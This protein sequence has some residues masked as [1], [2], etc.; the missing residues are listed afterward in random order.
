MAGPRLLAARDPANL[1]VTVAITL[2]VQAETPDAHSMAIE[3]DDCSLAGE[4]VDR[5]AAPL[6]SDRREGSKG[7]RACL[8]LISFGF[9][10]GPPPANHVFDVSFLKNPARENGWSLWSDPG[11]KMREWVVQQP[12]ASAFVQAALP[13][14]RVL[15][16]VDEDARVA[17]GCSAGRH[18]SA[19]LV[20]E[21]ARVLR[22]EN[23]EVSVFHRE[24]AQLSHSPQ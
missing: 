23:V 24:R 12:E 3:I 2:K 14:L 18:R 7:T 17:F 13:L 11:P 15:A 20:E 4:R 6:P 16:R 9:K 10:Y 8:T 21:I 5:V 19:I 1:A 22:E